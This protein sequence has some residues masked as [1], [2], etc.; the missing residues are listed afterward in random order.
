MEQVLLNSQNSSS[1]DYPVRFRLLEEPTPL[2]GPEDTYWIAKAVWAA[3]Q[4]GYEGFLIY[5]DETHYLFLDHEEAHTA[6]FIMANQRHPDLPRTSVLAKDQVVREASPD[7]PLHSADLS[8]QAGK[9]SLLTSLPLRLLDLSSNIRLLIVLLSCL[10]SI[11][12]YRF[13]LPAEFAGMVLILPIVLASWLFQ[14]WG[15]ALSFGIFLLFLGS[16][17]AFLPANESLWTISIIG[18]I[19]T[20]LIALG[21]RQLVD[22]LF[23]AQQESLSAQHAYERE[24]LL[25]QTKE[26]ILHHLNHEL[27]TPLTQIQGYLELL[28]CYS[29]EIDAP[30]RSAYLQRAQ[31]GCEELLCLINAALETTSTANT[32]S[33]N[34]KIVSLKHEIQM[35]VKHFDPRLLENYDLH[36]DVPDACLVYGDQGF[37]RQIMRNL[38]TNAFKYTTSHTLIKISATPLHNEV[39]GNGQNYIPQICVRVQDQGPGIPLEQQP[40]IFQQ[41]VRLPQKPAETVPGTGLGLYICKQLVETMGGRIWVES[42]GQPGSGCCFAFTLTSASIEGGSAA[43]IREVS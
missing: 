39:N 17:Y 9:S 21:V 42:T 12:L 16:T 4:K 11:G 8:K 14:W 25:N 10:F 22:L 38:F 27:R 15:Y 3:D 43:S 29:E 23:T 31:G 6:S 36:L 20:G 18:G 34:P 32:L 2:A 7:P 35:V 1:P 40:Q 37:V 41:F 19:L 33:F 5:A 26:Q 30:Q 13:L 24:R 28:D